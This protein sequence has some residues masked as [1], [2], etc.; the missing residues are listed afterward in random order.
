MKKIVLVTG[1]TSGIGKNI[2]LNMAKKG[3]HVIIHG[4]NE[5]KAVNVKNEIIAETHNNDIDIAIADLFSLEDVKRM[6]AELIRKYDHLDILMN[7]AGAILDKDRKLTSEG[8]EST[9]TLNVFSPFL[10]TT[11]LLPLLKKSPEARLINTSS[12]MHKRAVKPDFD[13]FQFAN[14]FETTSVYGNSKLYVIWLTQRWAEEFKKLQIDNIT[15]N[16]YQPGAVATNF[17]QDSHKGF[18]TDLVFKIALRFSLMSSIDKGSQ[19]AIYL[20][21]SP[22]V[23]NTTGKFYDNKMRLEKAG[24]KYYSPEN[25]EKVWEECQQVVTPYLLET[26]NN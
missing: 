12:E 8:L 6:A 22:E 24:V 16:A 1:A 4:R 11:L 5:A 19:S 17:G 13:D 7:N 3:Y 9:L 15:I 26:V 23:I 20:A 2:A 21:T 10:L 25:V 18:F 14:N